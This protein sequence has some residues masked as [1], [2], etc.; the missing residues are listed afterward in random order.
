MFDY[1]HCVLQSQSLSAD[2]CDAWRE[3][4]NS[5]RVSK[6]SPLFSPLEILV[7][8]CIL[9]ILSSFL[10]LV[11]IFCLHLLFTARFLGRSLVLWIVVKAR[12]SNMHLRLEIIPVYDPVE[13]RLPTP[14]AGDCTTWAGFTATSSQPMVW[15]PLLES[16]R[17]LAAVCFVPLLPML[18]QDWVRKLLVIL[19]T[20]HPNFDPQALIKACWNVSSCCQRIRHLRILLQLALAFY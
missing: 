5:T 2:R 14:C 6:L 15:L 19:L 9:W 10:C 1:L 11:S 16:W 3:V 17:C 13:A 7:S 20:L 4:A 8:Q 18:W 12:A